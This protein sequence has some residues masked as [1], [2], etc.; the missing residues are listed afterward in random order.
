MTRK[1]RRKASYPRSPDSVSLRTRLGLSRNVVKSPLSRS[2]DDNAL[3]GG[4]EGNP[5]I[6]DGVLVEEVSIFL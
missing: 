5:V 1:R 6:V 2:K 3:I 4:T